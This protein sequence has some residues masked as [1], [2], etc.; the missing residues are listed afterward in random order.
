[1]LKEKYILQRPE[2]NGLVIGIFVT[3]DSAIQY[4]KDK[5]L[6]PNLHRIRPIVFEEYADQDVGVIFT[7]LDIFTNPN[8]PRVMGEQTLSKSMIKKIIRGA[9]FDKIITNDNLDYYSRPNEV[10]L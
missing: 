7:R 6:D 2:D 3:E 5:K 10:Q 9:K 4:A 1:M 8:M